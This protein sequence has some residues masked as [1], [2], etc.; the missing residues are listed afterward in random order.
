[1]ADLIIKPTSGTGN[2]LILQNQAGNAIL[3]T[4]NIATDTI[5]A[6]VAGHVIKITT[7]TATPDVTQSG[8][9]YAQEADANDVTVTCTS[10]N[11]LHIWIVGGFGYA[12]SAVGYFRHGLV[13]KESG[14]S[15]VVFFGS[16][17]YQRSTSLYYND[18]QPSV[19]YQHTAITTS[20]TIKRAVESAAGTTSYWQAINGDGIQYKIMEEQV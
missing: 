17:Q 11:K 18:T 19:M 3:T 12:A 16:Y 2:K 10:G 14:E 4:G 13:I 20:V 6:P 5:L 15:D 1:M 8:A 9:G 7:H